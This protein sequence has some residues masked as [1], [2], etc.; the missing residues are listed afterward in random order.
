[1]DYI[2][3]FFGNKAVTLV[4]HFKF[5][6]IDASNRVK[7][8]VHH[9]KWTQLIESY[10]SHGILPPTMGAKNSHKMSKLKDKKNIRSNRKR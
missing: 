7:Q 5:E 1:M 2:I 3:A 8:K 6:P 9:D 10:K 4:R